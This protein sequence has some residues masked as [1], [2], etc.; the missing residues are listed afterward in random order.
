VIFTSHRYPEWFDMAR[1]EVLSLPEGRRKTLLNDASFGRF[2]GDSN[3]GYLTYVR[4]GTLFATP[5][6][7]V[8]LEGRGTPVPLL[9]NLEYDPTFGAAQVDMSTTGALVYRKWWKRTLVWLDAS[10]AVRPLPF[11]P[12]RASKPQLAPDGN[13]M[14]FVSEGAL[15]V[16]DFRRGVRTQITRDVAV[17]GPALWTPDGQFIAFS[18]PENIWSVRSDGGAEPR[19][20]LPPKPSAVRVATSIQVGA[21]NGRLAF[22][23]ITVG[24]NDLWDLWTVPIRIDDTGL[25][26]AEP[27][28]FLK[29]RHDERDLRF[30]PKGDW[31]AYS[32][33]ESAGRAEI[34]VRAFPNDGRRWKITEGGGMY[35]VWSKSRPELFFRADRKI[36]V[37]PYAVSAGAFT[38]AQPRAWSSQAIDSSAIV[39]YSVSGDGLSV[40]TLVADPTADEQSRHVISLWTN[41]L[42]ELRRRAGGSQH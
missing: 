38:T 21:D 1:V 16:Y 15:W 8:R 42:D 25:H 30:S 40:V 2:I 23:E 33:T 12:G 17:S 28:V 36:M 39:P 41:P 35:P 18:T 37:V 10:G 7:S 6:D 24:G 20:L 13:R 11:Q 26:A 22:E 34:Y 19:P 4:A 31:V 32:S 29:T 27:E 9:E 3:G 14:A 5:F